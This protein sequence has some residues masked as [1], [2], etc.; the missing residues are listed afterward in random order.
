MLYGIPRYERCSVS[1]VENCMCKNHPGIFYINDSF[2]EG[3]FL[4]G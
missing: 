4:Y 3:V 2:T 1:P